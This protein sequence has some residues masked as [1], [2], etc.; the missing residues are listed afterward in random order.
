MGS[1][2]L[3][4]ETLKMEHLN[5]LVKLY[6]SI[7]KKEVMPDYF[8]IKFGMEL[9]NVKQS[10]MVVK[11]NGKV[12]GF[13]G[14]IHQQ[15]IKGSKRLNLMYA[16]D[17]FLEEAYRG[18]GVFARLYGQ[19]LVN[20]K[21]NSVDHLY[22]FH[23]E[24]T[25]KVCKRLGWQDRE[26]LSR[27]HIVG[28][29]ALVSKALNKAG[30]NDWKLNILTQALKKY[31]IEINDFEPS[32]PSKFVLDYDESFLAMKRFWK[33]FFVEIE[34]CRLWLKFDYRITVG[35]IHFIDDANIEKMI[36]ELQRI[37]KKSYIHDVVFH[38]HP[39]NKAHD[40]LKQFLEARPSF[41]MSCLTLESDS[42]SF[43][44]LSFHFMDGDLF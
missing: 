29:S 7:F 38:I 26:G 6:K 2:E 25:Y 23:S 31:E 19:V 21:K 30:F 5:A 41:K 3:T 20:A 40:K 14:A 16:C 18:D 8:L 42:E 35:Y 22:A 13:F 15:T 9:P 27:F 17:F 39:T 32:D 4:F 12:V 24:Q 43:T 10:S 36:S 28:S 37:A 11:D 1:I 34:G 33:R 44:E